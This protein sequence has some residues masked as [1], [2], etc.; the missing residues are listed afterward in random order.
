MDMCVY[1][2]ITVYMYISLHSVMI[3]DFPFMIVDFP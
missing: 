2:S 3:V 1:L